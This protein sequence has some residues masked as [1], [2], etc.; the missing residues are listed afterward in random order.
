MKVALLGNSESIHC[1]R[2]ANGLVARGVDVVM[3]SAHPGT[4]GID[5]AVDMRVLPTRV[6][7][8]Y[9]TSASQLRRIFAETRPDIVNAHYATGYGLLARLANCRPLMLSVWGADVYD[10]PRKSPLHAW[11]LRGNLEAAD[12]IGST[13]ECM[14]RETRRTSSARPIF[15][16]PFGVDT[17]VFGLAPKPSDL[18][19]QVVVGTVKTL[20]HKYGID[21]LVQAFAQAWDELGRPET[22]R[23]EIGGAG[24]D[25]V[26]LGQLCERLGIAGQVHFHGQVP[27]SAVPGLIHRMDVF[28]ALSRLDSESFGV[29][30]VEAAACGKPVLVSD[31]QGLAEVTLDGVTG[32]VVPKNDPRAAALE[33][34]R[35][36]E[37]AGLRARMGEAGRRHVEEHYSW[38]KS[39]D[40][41]LEAY[42]IVLAKKRVL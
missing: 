18:Q 20:S 5:P 15:V 34:R 28:A 16:T 39:L 4:N 17:R 23:L 8:G 40:K 31:A 37:D 36:I 22:L 21:T 30:A 11:L 9:V 38:E 32:I 19:H 24:E 14:A 26:P 1:V 41:M 2:W 3:I 10:F 12:A 35:L 13:S 33:L 42:R 6:P 27:H 25:R 29:A 7:L